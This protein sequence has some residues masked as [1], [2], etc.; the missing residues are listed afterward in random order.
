MSDEIKWENGDL[1]KVVENGRTIIV[2]RNG[3]RCSKSISEIISEVREEINNGSTIMDNI[4][5]EE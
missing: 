2:T 4:I 5:N 1:F 3:V